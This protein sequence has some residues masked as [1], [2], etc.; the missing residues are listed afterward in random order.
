MCSVHVFRQQRIVDSCLVAFSWDNSLINMILVTLNG[1]L[2][3]K[4]V[5]LGICWIW[6]ESLNHCRQRKSSI[7]FLSPVL[8]CSSGPLKN[9]LNTFLFASVKEWICRVLFQLLYGEIERLRVCCRF[10]LPLPHRMEKGWWLP[11]S[12]LL[13]M[14]VP[15]SAWPRVFLLPNWKSVFCSASLWRSPSQ[16][17]F[18]TCG[19]QGTNANQFFLSYR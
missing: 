11:G 5:I 17:C 15:W 1:S 19:R 4:L 6:K 2:L 12:M 18:S 8:S 3:F 14:A 7:K 16:L 13:H 9:V 10:V